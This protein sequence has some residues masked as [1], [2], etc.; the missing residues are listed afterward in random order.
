MSTKPKERAVESSIG[1]VFTSG[2]IKLSK[3][4]KNT[5]PTVKT[6]R[7]LSG[8]VGLLCRIWLWVF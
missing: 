3:K 7:R 6:T 4:K 5:I 8:F 2:K 1:L